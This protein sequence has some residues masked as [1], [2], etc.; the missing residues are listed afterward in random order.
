MAD[1]NGWS[2]LMHWIT[3]NGAV[4]DM[5]GAAAKVYI[6]M[7]AHTDSTFKEIWPSRSRIQNLTKLKRNAVDRAIANLVDLGVIEKL[8]CKDEKKG[9]VANR[10]KITH[11]P[12]FSNEPTLRSNLNPGYVQGS[13]HPTFSDGDQT[14]IREQDKQQ[15]QIKRE[16]TIVR[17]Y[18]TE[19]PDIDSVVVAI[20]KR[21]KLDKAV[22][23]EMG[24]FSADRMQALECIA[25]TKKSPSGYFVKALREGW[26][27]PTV[28]DK[29]FEMECDMIRASFTHL[30]S[31]KT[32]EIYQILKYK[33]G[34]KLMISFKGQELAIG[35]DAINQYD[36][37]NI[38]A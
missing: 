28:D 4:G 36:Q 24:A 25:K 26:S 15:Q 12:T 27:I 18:E 6:A 7:L 17:E 31:K 33:P 3:N 32:G 21:L 1:C 10:Y 16:T 14:R 11:T 34:P 19:T 30:K 22:W 23:A 29:A 2:K 5:T 13:T 8:V 35:Q 20:F 9:Y 38:S 37:E